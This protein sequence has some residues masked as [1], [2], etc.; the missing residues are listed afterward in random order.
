MAS[1]RRV[2][3]NG[4]EDGATKPGIACGG[5]RGSQQL[6]CFEGVVLGDRHDRLRGRIIFARE[7][8][9]RPVD[10]RGTFERQN[11]REA[12]SEELGS[13][14]GTRQ[15]WRRSSVAE[16]VPLARWREPH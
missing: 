3:A 8:P 1:C 11:T 2:N 7:K 6:E 15:A 13:S 14:E 5:E 4:R 10:S 16:S 9:S 12:G